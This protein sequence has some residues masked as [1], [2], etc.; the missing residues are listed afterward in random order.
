[1][2]Q[3]L[4]NILN[5]QYGFKIAD[6]FK[7]T[8]QKISDASNLDKTLSEIKTSEIFSNLCILFLFIY[9]KK[10]ETYFFLSLIFAKTYATHNFLSEIFYLI[11]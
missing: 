6:S 4:K 2:K 8:T 10:I 7:F 11:C 1:M 5:G 9:T 3:I